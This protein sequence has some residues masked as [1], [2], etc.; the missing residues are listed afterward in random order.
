MESRRLDSDP[1][2]GCSEN[3]GF[4][5]F[6]LEC[7]PFWLQSR[8]T[9]KK[10]CS[11]RGGWVMCLFS[12]LLATACSSLGTNQIWKSC[13]SENWGL[14]KVTHP[15]PDL[16]WM[17]PSFKRQT[18]KINVHHNPPF[19]LSLNLRKKKS[20]D[21]HLLISQVCRSIHGKIPSGRLDYL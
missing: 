9:Q 7:I 10:E 4:S 16:V 20:L 5:L 19:N 13:R 6:I 15:L 3:T 17:Y 2:R 11:E 12:G 14:V 21:S 1:I 8:C 18:K